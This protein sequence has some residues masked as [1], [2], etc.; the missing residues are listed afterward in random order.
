[1]TGHYLI[2]VTQPHVILHII[3]GMI[4]PLAITHH[5]LR[6]M[7]RSLPCPS[8]LAS[9]TGRPTHAKIWDSGTTET[10]TDE[11]ALCAQGAQVREA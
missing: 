7:S 3:Y 4:Y 11:R 10:C 8:T 6:T 2:T 5:H 1:M 9:E